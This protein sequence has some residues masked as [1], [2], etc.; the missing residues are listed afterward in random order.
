MVSGRLN[1]LVEGL[2]IGRLVEAS[3]PRL[4]RDVHKAL[5]DVLHGAHLTS[6]KGV[7]PMEKMKKEYLSGLLRARVVRVDSDT[8]ALTSKGLQY[9]HKKTRSMRDRMAVESIRVALEREAEKRKAA[10]ERGG[11]RA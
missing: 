9:L 4:S 6:I 11:G 10:R 1:A 3:L 8:V 2:R 5:L 7:L